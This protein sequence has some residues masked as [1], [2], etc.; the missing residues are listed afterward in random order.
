MT[1]EW[2]LFWLEYSW[3]VGDYA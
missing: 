2:I 3:L 1:L